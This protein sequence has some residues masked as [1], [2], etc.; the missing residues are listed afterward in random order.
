[1]GK[2]QHMVITAGPTREMLDPVRFLSNVSTG[3]MGYVLA[4][5]AERLGFRVTLVSGPTTL[6][7]PDGVMFVP[8]VTAQEMKQALSEAWPT[9]DIL[10]MT[11]AV[12]D[13]T[14][15]EYSKTKIKR[16]EQ[17]TICLRQTEDIVKWFGE[18]KGKRFVVGFALETENYMANAV[19]KLQEKNLDLIVLN[20]YGQGNNPFGTA[21]TSM[22]LVD[23]SGAQKKLDRMTKG[24]AAK[25]ILDE[26][27]KRCAKKD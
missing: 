1:M 13:Y 19:R 11:A 8:V 23:R 9:A 7:P 18:Q 14:P 3:V 15:V 27:L 24:D 2:K 12:C 10:V 22:I 26:I 17:Q 21:Q 6:K 4:R 20:W 5:Q 16:I 25:I